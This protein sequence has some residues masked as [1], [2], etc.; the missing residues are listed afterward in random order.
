M[1]V[2]NLQ[3][4][5]SNWC[6]GKKLVLLVLP[7]SLSSNIGS[8]SCSRLFSIKSITWSSNSSLSLIQV[9]K[10]RVTIIQSSP[11]TVSFFASSTKLSREVSR[12]I[13]HAELDYLHPKVEVVEGSRRYPNVSEGFTQRMVSRVRFCRLRPEA[14][15]MPRRVGRYAAHGSTIRIEEPVSS[16]EVQ[17]RGPTSASPRVAAG[18]TFN[19]F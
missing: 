16:G 5:W 2:N 14:P 4:L 18:T 8:P 17:W 9:F 6:N 15:A 12:R 10:I 3:I 7:S 19:M 1:I 13:L 11:W